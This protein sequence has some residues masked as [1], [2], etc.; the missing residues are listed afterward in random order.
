MYEW[1][2]PFTQE[3]IHYVPV[4]WDLSDLFSQLKW[5][6]ANEEKSIEISKNAH[7]LGLSLFRPEFMACYSY[8]LLKQFHSK[9]QLDDIRNKDH[10]FDDVTMVCDRKRGKQNNCVALREIN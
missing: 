2:E 6:R 3:W 7:K 1:F 8:C 5:A 10:T 4:K 9:L